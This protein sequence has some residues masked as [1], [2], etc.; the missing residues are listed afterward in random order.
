MASI[1]SRPRD[2]RQELPRAMNTSFRCCRVTFKTHKINAQFSVL[3]ATMKMPSNLIVMS[4]IARIQTASLERRNVDQLAQVGPTFDTAS[5]H[6]SIT[7]DGRDL[8]NMP[9]A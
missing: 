5:G 4:L 1:F 6:L 9:A 8:A 2:Y 7:V 3:A